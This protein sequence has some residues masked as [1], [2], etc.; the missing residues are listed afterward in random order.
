MPAKA[1]RY[2][3]F[4]SAFGVDVFAS[5]RFCSLRL[6]LFSYLASSSGSKPDDGFADREVSRYVLHIPG[7]HS[8]IRRPSIHE[9]CRTYLANRRIV[10]WIDFSY[11]GGAESLDEGRSPRRTEV[12]TPTAAD[13]GKAHPGPPQDPSD[14]LW[15]M[16]E[17][18]H[19][20][21]RMAI[22]KAHPE[23]CRYTCRSHWA[24]SEERT[25]GHK[26]DGA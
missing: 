5:V 3:L 21:R 17:E 25:T 2:P 1:P 16:T 6:A 4:P 20:T 11:Y 19:R 9:P 24:H 22:M 23:V 13:N 7:V 18:P 8:R 12:P 15:L 10:M 26:I 14:F